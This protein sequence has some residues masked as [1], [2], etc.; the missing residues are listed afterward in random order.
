MW[1]N[2]VSHTLL[3]EWKN[4]KLLWMASLTQW[5]RVWANPGRWWRTGSLVC[6]S[7]WGPAS[8]TWLSEQQRSAKQVG[9]FKKPSMQLPHNWLLSWVSISVIWKLF[10]PKNLCANVYSNFIYHR[11]KKLGGGGR[12]LSIAEWMVK[13]TM[14]HSYHPINKPAWISKELWSVRKKKSKRLCTGQFY[15]YII[16]EVTQF[17]EMINRHMVSRRDGKGCQA[18]AGVVLEGNLKDSNG[19]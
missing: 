16:L 18:K 4:D 17:I 1:R 11:S 7:P 14:V 3:V 13:Q 19:E 6:C 8:P 10:G 12:C 2:G 15:L 9:S 5:T